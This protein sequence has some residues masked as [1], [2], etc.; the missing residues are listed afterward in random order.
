MTIH[1]DMPTLAIE[2]RVSYL[3]P[4]SLTL[5]VVLHR[6]GGGDGVDRLGPFS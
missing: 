2:G 4:R 5:A 1:C 6:S 3:I